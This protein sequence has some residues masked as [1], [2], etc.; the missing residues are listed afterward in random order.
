MLTSVAADVVGLGAS[1]GRLQPG[2]D[3]DVVAVDGDPLTD[4]E[5][6]LRPVG[7]WHRGRR[8]V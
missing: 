6:L 5:A 7:V 8:V 4:P 1:K 3:A 2:F